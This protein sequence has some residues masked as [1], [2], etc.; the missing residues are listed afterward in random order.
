MEY[1]N[2]IENKWTWMTHPKTANAEVFSSFCI[3]ILYFWIKNKK[4]RLVNN[5][6]LCI[7][8][9]IFIIILFYFVENLII[10]LH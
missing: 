5:Q 2:N 9:T 1:E 4:Y 3:F 10:S 6:R 8:N 7:F